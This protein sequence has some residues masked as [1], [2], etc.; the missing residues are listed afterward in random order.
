MESTH[1]FKDQVFQSSVGHFEMSV[2]GT[3]CFISFN[4]EIEKS[5]TKK[6]KG[7]ENHH[8]TEFQYLLTQM[9]YK[10]RKRQHP[11]SS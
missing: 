9:K 7:K 2:S 1:F 5:V 11:P 8:Q 6:K 4:F 10:A 3:D